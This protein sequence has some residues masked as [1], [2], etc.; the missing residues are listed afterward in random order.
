MADKTMLNFKYGIFDRLP[1]TQV[2]GTVYVTA[3]EKAMYVD[4]PAVTG[5]D[6]ST[7]AADRV[8]ISQIVVKNSSRDAQP[9]FSADAFYYFVEENALLKWNPTGG[10]EGKGAWTQ[11]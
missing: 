1:E 4:L 2:P 10:D 9:P 3:D 5:K 7:I 8:R 6:G 11:G